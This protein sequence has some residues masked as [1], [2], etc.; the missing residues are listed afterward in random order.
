MAGGAFPVL[1]RGVSWLTSQGEVLKVSWLKG[2]TRRAMAT[3]ARAAGEGV[4]MDGI[5]SLFSAD[6]LCLRR[7]VWLT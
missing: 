1:P 2:G 5:M 4:V 3:F 7:R 6:R